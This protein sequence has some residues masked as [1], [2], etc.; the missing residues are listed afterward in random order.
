METKNLTIETLSPIFI[1]KG[2]DYSKFDYTVEMKGEISIKIY[3][4]NKLINDLPKYIKNK[5][6]LFEILDDIENGVMS[7]IS[8]LG[9][10][11]LQEFIRNIDLIFNLESEELSGPKNFQR[12]KT[13]PRNLN[14]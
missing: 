4:V 13:V 1:W 12:L 14:I 5:D 3:D 10:S 11:S 7:G 2:E 8:G 6:K 9:F